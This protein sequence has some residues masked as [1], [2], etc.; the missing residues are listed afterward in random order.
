ME[1]RTFE[2]AR[3]VVRRHSP[4]AE[5]AD[6]GGQDATHWHVPAWDGFIGHGP[7]LV[8]KADGAVTML[9]SVPPW[10]QL[11]AMARVGDWPEDA[12]GG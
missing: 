11:D 12:D 8:A 2:E 7:L 5:I 1:V 4:L 6:Y 10:P 3:A 9:P